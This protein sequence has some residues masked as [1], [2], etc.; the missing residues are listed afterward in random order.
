MSKD[1][2]YLGR[3]YASFKSAMID[4]LKSYFPDTYTDFT[5]ADPGMMNLD[6]SA[7]VGDVLSFYTDRQVQEN[8]NE[9]AQLKENLI[10]QAYVFGYRPKVTATAVVDL[11]VYQQVP[12]IISASIASPD[13]NYCMIV[14][15]EAKVK[16]S[17]N[18]SIVFITQD[19]VDF[20][21]SSS[22]DPTDIS[23]YQINTGTNQPD[24]Y[25]FKKTVKAI[26][27]T[28]KSQDFTF[29]S[30]KKFDSVTLQDDDIIEV[31]NVVD[32]DGNKWYEVPYLAQNTVYEDIRNTTLNDPF[33]SQYSNTAPYLLRLRKVQRRFVSRFN[34]VDKL[35][36]YFGSGISSTPD[37]EVI[38][39]SDNIGL[40]IIDS[41]SKLNMAYDPSNFLYTKEY[42]LIPSNTTLT[43][44][45]ITGGGVETNVP[46]NDLSQVYEVTTSPVSITPS[47]LNQPLLTAIKNS[48]AFNNS[49]PASGGGDGDSIEDIRLKTVASFPAQMRNVTPEDHM[50]RA[51]SMPPKF[52][53]VAKAYLVQ[54]YATLSTGFID[55]NP[56]AL[57]LYILSYD[58][59]KNLTTASRAIK[60]NLQAYIDQHKITNDAVNIKD[61]YIINIG[62]NFDIMVLSS[63]NAK[64]V[65]PKALDAVKA[66]FDIDKWT[67]NQPIILSDIDTAIKSIP[68]VQNVMNIQVVCKYGTSN[69]YSQY[70]YDITGATKNGIIYCSIDPMCFEIKFPNQNIQGRVVNS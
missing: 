18:S 60:E 50:I 8:F 20:S 59:K 25:L 48:I 44:K 47:T 4:F 23:V 22:A 40:G 54:D 29:T 61:A 39:N 5:D 28:I 58:A 16:S 19:L 2:K 64:E 15:K 41:I 57:S 52:G 13:Y 1:I 67:I 35:K 17:T 12:A 6:V 49:E 68:G 36:L 32:S 11:D 3:D 24:Y 26:A 65:L 30:P 9:F 10:S 70:A 69:G 21:F 51:I 7:A 63:Y 42:G 45:Y 55:N 14:D 37:E 38:P 34:A 66:L 43:V 46:A 27:G 31:L 56:L 33:L 53:T 62:I